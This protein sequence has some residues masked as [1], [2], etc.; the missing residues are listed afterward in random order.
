M[1][2]HSGQPEQREVD[3]YSGDS[4]VSSAGDGAVNDIGRVEVRGV[5]DS[6]HTSSNDMDTEGG[7]RSGGSLP[8]MMTTV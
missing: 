8:T 6:D 1:L 4:D 5:K 2:L 3:L 7:D